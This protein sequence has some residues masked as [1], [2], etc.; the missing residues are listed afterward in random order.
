MDPGPLRDALTLGVGLLTGV[1][2][3]AFGVGGAVLSTP[4]IRLLGASAF[5]AVGTTLP[6]ILP[7][8]ISGTVRYARD[9]LIDWHVVQWTAP[10]GV[11]SAVLGSLASHAVPGNGHW[12]MVMTAFFLGLTA[13]RVRPRAAVEPTA[14]GQTDDGRTRAGARDRA[15]GDA[16]A[17]DAVGPQ[18]APGITY[19]AASPFACAAV[20]GAAGGL[21]GLLG[22]GGG[23]VMVP[24]FTE[25]LGMP[26]KR[27]IATSLACVGVFAVPGTI[28]H[29]A[30]GDIDWRFA[31]L[32]AV[33][34]V[35]GARLGAV[36]AIRA[37]DRRLQSAVALFLG[38]L[39]IGYGTAEIIAAVR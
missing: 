33:A 39:A 23:I 12:L 21:S 20:G 26:I 10:V 31:L 17:A 1:L 18:L 6:S 37:D 5:V 25:V 16:A 3:A 34:V 8:A 7:S 2:S 27:A 22:V 19:G 13:W 36:I 11:V 30:L 14:S 28:T 35:P 24:G 4:G 15:D 32:L 38:A 9:D 29:A